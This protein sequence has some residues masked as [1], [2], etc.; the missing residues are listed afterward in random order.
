M[1]LQNYINSHPN[2]ISEFRAQ[3]LKVN[4][5]KGLKIVSYLY[6]NPPSEEGSWKML[7]KGA[8]INGNGQ[9]IC[10]PPVKA[11]SYENY[12]DTEENNRSYESLID[13]TMINLFYY[14]EEW[15]ISTR[16]EIGGYNKWNTKKSFRQ[17]FDECSKID[18][19]ILD[20][21]M[22]YS[23]VMKHTENRNVT[24]IKENELILVDVYQFSNDDHGRTIKRLITNEYPEN[25]YIVNDSFNDDDEIAG[26]M[27]L[28]QGPVI[29]YYMKG[30]TVKCGSKR[31]KWINP[32]FDEV[33]ALKINMNNHL[34]NYIELRRNGNLKK[35]LRYYPEHNHLFNGYKDNLHNM[36]NDLFTTYKNVFIH[37]STSKNDIPYHLKPMIYDI[38]RN[39]LEN[40]DPTTW[41][42]IKDYIHTIPSK[43]L[44]FALNYC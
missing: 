22:S 25:N 44:V 33:K 14:N 2:Y 6:E 39:Y 29:P 4:S 35:Y 17:M 12:N 23:F 15:L 30:F 28:Y 26:F 9:I 13:G 36:S 5:F 8:V 11:M 19:D 34:I 27:R 41:T 31:Y 32:Y 42:H 21:N 1:E 20:K 24:P 16:S 18:Y 37:K 10:L 7:C 40:K 43:K 3:G 38:H